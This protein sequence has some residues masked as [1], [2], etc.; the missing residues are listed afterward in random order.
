MKID[1]LTE[2]QQHTAIDAVNDIRERDDE[3]FDGQLPVSALTTL[4]VKEVIEALETRRDE[5][6]ED[7]DEEF[8]DAIAEIE[9]VLDALC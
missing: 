2:F 4:D 1:N 7:G 9:D 6:A 8:D 3:S 5:M